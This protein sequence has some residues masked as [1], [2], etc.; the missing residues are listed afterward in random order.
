MCKKKS[1]PDFSPT[2][3]LNISR[4]LLYALTTVPMGKDPIDFPCLQSVS[5]GPA[6]LPS[7]MAASPYVDLDFPHPFSNTVGYFDD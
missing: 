5:R 1:N 7:G 3:P 2:I 6:A 4:R